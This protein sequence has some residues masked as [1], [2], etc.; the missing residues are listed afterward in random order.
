LLYILQNQDRKL[1]KLFPI[2]KAENKS[3]SVLKEGKMMQAGN[4]IDLILFVQ[5]LWVSVCCL[6]TVVCMIRSRKEN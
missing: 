6:G 1:Y 4:G 5:V 2:I 3:L